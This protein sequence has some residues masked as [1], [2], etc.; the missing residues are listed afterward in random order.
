MHVSVSATSRIKKMSK[1]IG[2]MT[3]TNRPINPTSRIRKLR[4]P[5]PQHSYST[6][7]RKVIE[8]S[9]NNNEI[10]FNIVYNLMEK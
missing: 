2:F 7:T 3:N 8:Y 4:V 10:F 5:K 1:Y 6:I 9:L